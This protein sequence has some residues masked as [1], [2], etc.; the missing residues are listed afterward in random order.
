MGALHT[1]ST[2]SKAFLIDLL[3]GVVIVRSDGRKR[4]KLNRHFDRQSG[5]AG[6]ASHSLAPPDSKPKH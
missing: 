1:T 6:G 2:K 5:R 4:V 3:P